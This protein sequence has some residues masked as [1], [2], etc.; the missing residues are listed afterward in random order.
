MKLL[1]IIFVV[2]ASIVSI[3]AVPTS[4]KFDPITFINAPINVPIFSTG[5]SNPDYFA[6]I[7]VSKQ[8]FNVCLDTG[9]V[10]LW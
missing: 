7:E 3:S 1:H 9:S 5:G 6:E 10:N 8:K 2:T 4:K